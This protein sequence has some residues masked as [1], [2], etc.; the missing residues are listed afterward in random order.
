MFRVG[1][2]SRLTRVPVKTLRYYDDIGLFKPVSVDRFTGYRYYSIEQLPRLNRLLALRAIG[3]SLEHIGRIL[4]A[5]LSAEQLQAMLLLRQ[6][7]LEQD[8]VDLEERL[9]RVRAFLQE[10]E[11]EGKMSD[12]QVVIKPIASV[13]VAGAR[14]VVPQPSLMRERCGALHNEVVA[15]MKRHQLKS[16][17]PSLALYHDSSAEGIDVEMAYFVEAPASVPPPEGAAQVHTLPAEET[18]ASAVYHGSY[19]AFE[20]VSEVYGAVGRWIEANGYRINGASR[21]LYLQPPDWATKERIGVMEI[22][23]PVVKR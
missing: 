13:T 5:E 9:A 2:F 14:E 21:E 23:F 8:L 3:F 16:S 4:D 10:I 7:E 6:S 12:I 1:D 19:D 22:Q 20:A 18:V 15:Y 17:S 11:R